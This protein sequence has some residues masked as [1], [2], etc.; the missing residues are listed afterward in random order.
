MGN[1]E[2]SVVDSRLKVWG[3]DGLR[4]VDG[5]I[6]PRIASGDTNAACMVISEEA[7]ELILKERIEAAVSCYAS[8]GD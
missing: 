1:D 2:F 3:I 5:S 8:A 6:T 7:S 4:V